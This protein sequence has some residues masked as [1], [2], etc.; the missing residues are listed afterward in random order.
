MVPG[1]NSQLISQFMNERT[2]VECPLTERLDGIWYCKNIPVDE[3][4]AF[5]EEDEI[6]L[7]TF[8]DVPVTIVFIGMNALAS[9]LKAQHLAR[10]G[11]DRN[12]RVVIGE[13]TR[14]TFEATC[15]VPLMEL[16]RNRAPEAITLK[17]VSVFHE[18]GTR[19]GFCELVRT[20]SDSLHRYRAS[21]A[22]EYCFRLW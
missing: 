1:Q 2:H 11:K 15:T 22:A 7:N 13:R 10:V 3:A 18:R 21:R 20:T 9:R 14:R 4:C 8:G 5:D 17:K 6:I 16:C 12:L 19:D